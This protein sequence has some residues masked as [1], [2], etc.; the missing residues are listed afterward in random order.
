MRPSIALYPASHIRLLQRAVREIGKLARLPL[1]P[2]GRVLNSLQRAAERIARMGDRLQVMKQ[3]QP[4]AIGWND[5]GFAVAGNENVEVGTRTLLP[6]LRRHLSPETDG[7]TR[8]VQGIVTGIGFLG[9]GVIFRH[10]PEELSL[11]GRGGSLVACGET[12]LLRGPEG[13]REYYPGDDPRHVDWKVFAKS[14]RYY[15]KQFE[16]QLHGVAQGLFHFIP[17]HEDIHLRRYRWFRASLHR[18]RQR[19]V[20]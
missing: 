6:Y 1:D 15:L 3:G 4:R 10:G 18:P 16:E 11:H 17:E 7:V 19:P 8:V 12:C 5:P 14:D 20:R 13:A 2:S 9:A